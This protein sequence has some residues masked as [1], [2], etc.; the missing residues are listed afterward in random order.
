MVV[1]T[2]LISEVSMVKFAVFKFEVASFSFT[3][4]MELINVCYLIFSYS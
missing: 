4:L 1:P 2:Q 3:Q